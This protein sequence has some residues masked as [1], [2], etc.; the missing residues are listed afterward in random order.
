[1]CGMRACL[2]VVALAW[3][4]AA[5]APTPQSLAPLP[6]IRAS[7]LGPALAERIKPLLATLEA[8]PRDAAAG[9]AGMFLLAYE[10]HDLAVA[11]FDRARALE[12]DA[13]RW[14]YF[15]GV[16]LGSLGRYSEAL[17]AFRR[18][19]ELDSEF[20]P[21]RVRLAEAAFESN[22]LGGSREAYQSLVQMMP[23]DPRIRYGAGRAAAA[24]GSLEA[25]QHHLLRAVDLLP[26]YGE[27]H[28]A[29]ALLLREQ[30]Q[31]RASANHLELFERNPQGEPAIRDPLLR[32][33]RVSAA[34]HL[35][36]GVEAKAAGRV[37]EAIALHLK[38][39]EEDPGLVQARV[40]LVILYGQQ[41]QTDDAESQYHA[42]MQAGAQS[43]E[44]H[45]NYGVLAYQAR[46][47]EKARAAFQQALALNP[48]HA[49]ANHNAGQLLE[50]QGRFDEAMAHYRRALENRPDHGLSLY[51]MGMLWMRQRNARKA[52]QAFR[53]AAKEQSDRTPSY[54]FS[55]AAAELASG[56]RETAT[57][58]FEQARKTAQQYG[59]TGLVGRIDEAM[60][61][62]TG[63]ASP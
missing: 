52:V 59:Q 31:D 23:D 45:Y 19:V 55:L 46:E 57:A 30:G 56:D 16:S 11:F 17:Q 58:R 26:T 47:A 14:E 9:R 38:A 8:E 33:V 15:L 60:R 40:N 13:F 54:L 48:D 25:A 35:R 49:L 42:A 62:L 21:A 7:E 5:C 18:C 3:V 20:H 4:F 2:R 50:E 29:L 22:D 10:Q 27:A 12:P 1:M 51:K 61:A 32:E 28:Y 6:E 41:G 24:A 43:A 53:E 39:L 63:A 36:Q 37:A 34:E 44:L